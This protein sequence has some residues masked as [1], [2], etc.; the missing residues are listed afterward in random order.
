MSDLIIKRRVLPHWTID[1]AWYYLTFCTRWGILCREEQI[2]VRD[3]IKSGHSRFYRLIAVSVMPDHV[4]VVLC[5][6]DGVSLS[7]IL[8]GIKGASARFI[9]LKRNSTGPIWQNESWDRIIRNDADLQQKLG[10]MLMN[11][12]EEGLVE[13]PWAYHGWYRQE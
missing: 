2:L 11:P 7:R 9:N 6:N 8:Q 1:G 4:H 12:V 13:D 5:P 10:Y 3:H